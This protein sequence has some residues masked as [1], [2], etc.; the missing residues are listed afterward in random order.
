MIQSPA[1]ICLEYKHYIVEH[2]REND[3]RKRLMLCGSPDRVGIVG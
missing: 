3:I 2:D 1:D